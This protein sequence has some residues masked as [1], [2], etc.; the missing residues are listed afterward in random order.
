MIVTSDYSKG[1][2]ANHTAAITGT[3]AMVA[4]QQA[5]MCAIIAASAASSAAA[6]SN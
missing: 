1:D 6:G 5:A 3:L 4:A 2:N